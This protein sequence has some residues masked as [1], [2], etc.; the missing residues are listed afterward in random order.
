[1]SFTCCIVAWGLSR[2][3]RGR[4]K[5]FW[6]VSRVAAINVVMSELMSWGRDTG[7]AK[8]MEG[9]WPESGRPGC[10]PLRLYQRTVALFFFFLF[11][12]GS[13]KQTTKEPVISHRRTYRLLCPRPREETKRGGQWTGYL[14]QQAKKISFKSP[15]EVKMSPQCE[16]FKSLVRLLSADG[17][18][19]QAPPTRNYYKWGGA[20]CEL[21]SIR[22]QGAP[23]IEPIRNWIPTRVPSF[24]S[25]CFVCRAVV[26][27]SS[28]CWGG[29]R[30]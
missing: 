23:A 9:A 28:A 21:C 6:R 1:M 27:T 24:T 22:T 25:V 8:G 18:T 11:T 30:V 3:G 7:T 20:L 13:H 26:N 17:C 19:G 29:G 15:K 5:R 16:L 10:Y 12:E 14:Q 2:V 4:K